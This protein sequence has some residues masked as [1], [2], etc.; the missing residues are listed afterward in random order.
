MEALKPVFT[1]MEPI[2]LIF[3]KLVTL[4]PKIV[5]SEA[6]FKF[7]RSTINVEYVVYSL[8]APVL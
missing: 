7:Y 4:S 3:A 2:T 1:V 6:V 8:R 5:N